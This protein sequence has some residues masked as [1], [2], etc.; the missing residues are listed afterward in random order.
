MMR[1]GVIG[2]G[3]MGQHHVRIYSEMDDVELVRISDVDE[4]RVSELAI[5]TVPLHV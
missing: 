3:A 1:V 4:K 5:H 2:T